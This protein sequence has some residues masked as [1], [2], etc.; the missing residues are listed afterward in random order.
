MGLYRKLSRWPWYRDHPEVL[1]MS[2]EEY[3]AWHRGRMRGNATAEYLERRRTEDTPEAR[4]DRRRARAEAAGRV[5]AGALK[6]SGVVAAGILAGILG[7]ARADNPQRDN[8]I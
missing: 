3:A 1:E 7:R 6:W 2:G 4:E 5:G 8:R